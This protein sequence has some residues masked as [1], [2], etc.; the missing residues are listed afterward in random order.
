MAPSRPSSNPSSHGCALGAATGASSGRTMSA[1]R[2]MAQT[3]CVS[4]GYFPC[5]SFPDKRILC[6]SGTNY[7]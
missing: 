6:R 3:L 4:A 5:A 2:F 1:A 7:I